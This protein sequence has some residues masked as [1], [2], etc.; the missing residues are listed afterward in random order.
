MSQNKAQDKDVGFVTMGKTMDK[1]EPIPEI[2]VGMI[3]YAFMGKAHSN[4]YKKMPYIFWP[5][6]AYPKL[7]KIA[8][9]N[10][11][12]VNEAAERYGFEGYTTDWHDLINDER[13]KILDNNGPNNVH[14][15]PCIEA[16]KAGMSVICEKPLARNAQEAREMLDAV[17]KA[18]VKNLCAFN[19]R[20][21]PAIRLARDIIESGRLG[22]IRHF[23]A[24]YLQE[25]IVDPS[26]PKVWRMNKEVSGSG[27]LGDFSHIVDLARY[28]CG[29]P[30]T[31]QALMKTFI[32]ERPLPDN[33]QK[34]EEVDVDDAF[35]AIVEFANGAIGFLEG[36]R[37]CPGRKNYEYIEI[38]GE[39][40]SIY[41]N[42]ENMNF[43][44]VYYRDEDP[45]DTQGFHAVDVTEAFHPYY[46]KWW[47]H[48]HIIGWENTF[49]HEAFHIVDAT[50]NGTELSPYIATFEDGYRAAVI[51]D[52]IIEAAESGRKKEIQY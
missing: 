31:V 5:P 14:A 6:P 16:A 13:I 52:A 11:A 2:G 3:G 12:A 10:K 22:A 51:C 18:G 37:F 20:T 19:Y 48:G 8:G 30:A 26:F 33:P 29:E 44:H 7:V 41:F 34:K 25:W 1:R 42:L 38:N 50:V 32:K 4:G 21:V 28:L 24:E 36:S 15:E 43:L 45:K 46:D 17:N 9:R 40:G 47:P 23:R 49:V 35:V 39:N 27:A